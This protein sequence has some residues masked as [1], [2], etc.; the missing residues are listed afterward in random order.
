MTFDLRRRRFALA[1]LALSAA[2]HRAMAQTSPDSLR[3]VVG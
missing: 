3:I 1:T 2:W